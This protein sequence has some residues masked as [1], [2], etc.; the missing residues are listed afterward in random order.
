MGMAARKIESK[1]AFERVNISILAMRYNLNRETVAKRLREAGIEPVEVKSKEK[2]FELTPGVTQVLERRNEA[3]EEVKLRGETARTE[4]AEI[5]VRQA[6]G[7]LVPMADAVELVRNIV[8][9]IYQE[10]TVRQPKRIAPKL[11]KSKNVTEVKKV[12]KADTDRIMKN[13]RENFERFIG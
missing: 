1:T 12:L 3:L 2:I 5:K 4:L 8:L 6:S 10:F 9:A 13:L 7:E 11:A